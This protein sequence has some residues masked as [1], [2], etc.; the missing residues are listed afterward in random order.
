MTYIKLCLIAALHAVII[1]AP[2][3][4]FASPRAPQANAR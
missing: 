2:M 1:V 3:N 4:A